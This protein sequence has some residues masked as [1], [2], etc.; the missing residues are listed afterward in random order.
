MVIM[1]VNSFLVIRSNSLEM[2]QK[3]AQLT[4]D[5]MV[6]E[7]EDKLESL[8]QYYL[9]SAM[10]EDIEWFLNNK[11]DYS[12]YSRYKQISSALGNNA[13]FPNHINSYVIINFNT[14]KVISSKG[15]YDIGEMINKAEIEELY[16]ENSMKVN[17]GNWVYNPGGRVRFHLIPGTGLPQIRKG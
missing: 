17:R 6:S 11:L 8:R 13:L 5:Q 1:I 7:V 3:E 15:I 10:D 2:S 4:T 14:G 9:Y 16:D 12:D